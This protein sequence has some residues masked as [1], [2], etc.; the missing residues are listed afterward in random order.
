[1]YTQYETKIGPVDTFAKIKIGSVFSRGGEVII[2]ASG[3]TAE[4]ISVA[5]VVDLPGVLLGGDLNIISPIKLL[6]ST[7]LALSIT[8]GKAHEDMAKRAQGKTVVHLHNDD[9]KEISLDFPSL[10]EQA[11][12]GNLFL[13]IDSL[14]T[15]HQRKC[16][17]LKKVKNSLLN[18]MFPN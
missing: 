6:D 10:D 17:L 14:I 18:K 3:E 7:F 9:L 13:N 15:L 5:S 11:N 16:D 2:P 1:M 8:Y 12:I 4:D